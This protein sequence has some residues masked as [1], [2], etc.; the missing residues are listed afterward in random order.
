MNGEAED[1]CP[2]E[3]GDATVHEE[4]TACWD[5][6]ELVISYELLLKVFDD[7]HTD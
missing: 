6:P 5:E 2:V 4:G 1:T 3:V 7:W